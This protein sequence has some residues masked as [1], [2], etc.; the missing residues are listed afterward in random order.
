MAS[1]TGVYTYNWDTAFAIPVPD[2]NKSIVDQQSSPPAF[3]LRRRMRTQSR[4][5]S[6]TGR[7]AWEGMARMYVLP[8]P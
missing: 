7:S 6:A 1:N 8:S 4:P 5:I 3:S 2:V